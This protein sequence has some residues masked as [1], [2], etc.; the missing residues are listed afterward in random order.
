MEGNIIF[1]LDNIP[2]NS[3]ESSAVWFAHDASGRLPEDVIGYLVRY[4]SD[5]QNEGFAG[6][7][8]DILM[9]EA[10]HLFSNITNP[11]YVVRLNKV[12]KLD[13]GNLNVMEFL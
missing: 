13:K 10:D 2:S 11:K 8:T 5:Y 1:K 4:R 6:I 3:N 9:H 12:A 7:R